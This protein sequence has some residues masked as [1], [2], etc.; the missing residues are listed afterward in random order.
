MCC[1]STSLLCEYL[2]LWLDFSHCRRAELAESDDTLGSCHMVVA[3][4]FFSGSFPFQTSRQTWCLDEVPISYPTQKYQLSYKTAKFLILI[5]VLMVTAWWIHTQINWI[6]FS[7]PILVHWKGEKMI[8]IF[9]ILVLH[10]W[11]IFDRVAHYSNMYENK[12]N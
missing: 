11:L 12:W 6:Y 2:G 3:F 7:Q 10:C 9:P 4:S 8:Q 1:A 5:L